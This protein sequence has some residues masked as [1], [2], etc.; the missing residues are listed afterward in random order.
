MKL[1]NWK[2]FDEVF[3]SAEWRLSNWE[4][5]LYTAA[6][7]IIYLLIVILLEY[8]GDF[9]PVTLLGLSTWWL[10]IFWF[11][12]R[13]FLWIKRCHDL[14]HSWAWL[15]W[16]LCPIFNLVFPFLLYFL[17]WDNWENKYWKEP[18][19]VSSKIKTITIIALIAWRS[20]ICYLYYTM[21]IGIKNWISELIQEA[22][23]EFNQEIQYE[24]LT[25][26]DLIDTFW[27][28]NI[29]EF[30]SYRIPK[31]ML[32][33]DKDLIELIIQSPSIL[34]MEDRQTWFDLYTLMDEEQISKLRDILTK[35]Q[36]KIEEI[37]SEYQ[38]W[39]DQT[40]EILEFNVVTVNA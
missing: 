9:L 33:N 25:Q 23:Q 15:L 30:S 13:I 29:E 21:F 8:I 28:G 17:K 39:E 32:E 11:I 24:S 36:D 18:E 16:Y 14:W 31:S 1:L 10:A 34:E 38:T 2:S 4:Y 35:E 7:C 22:N 3:L 20:G 37:E 6:W 40:W 27:T 12:C 5:M 26:E 19:K